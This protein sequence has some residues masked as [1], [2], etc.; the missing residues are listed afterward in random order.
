[1]TIMLFNSSSIR[2]HIVLGILLL[3]HTGVIAQPKA[4]E[5]STPTFFVE[6]F[7]TQASIS[8]SQAYSGGLAVINTKTY[9]YTVDTLAFEIRVTDLE[10]GSVNSYSIAPLKHLTL[11]LSSVSF[12]EADF[13]SVISNNETEVYLYDLKKECIEKKFSLRSA[14]KPMELLYVHPNLKIQKVDDY[15]IVPTVFGILDYAEKQTREKVFKNPPFILYNIKSM[16]AVSI[17]NGLYW[18]HKYSLKRN[19]K[20]YTPMISHDG[21]EKIF[22]SYKYSDSIVCYN[23]KSQ[24]VYKQKINLPVNFP[25]KGINEST[26]IP[27]FRKFKVEEAFITNYKFHPLQKE[28]IFFIKPASKFKEN[29]YIKSLYSIPW[30]I[31]VLDDQFNKKYEYDLQPN[32]AEWYQLGF[33]KTSVLLP[34]F[35]LKKEGGT[36]IRTFKGLKI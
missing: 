4:K 32:E 10:N 11:G 3:L 18:P 15:L 30:K 7:K 8:L 23:F 17:P 36:E 31:V 9:Y 12:L 34:S 21:K 27:E 19:F 26:D 33:T 35:I 25:E 6:E 5:P 2:I 29:G 1:M 24:K 16:E 13:I 14:L 28:H 20:N 22:L